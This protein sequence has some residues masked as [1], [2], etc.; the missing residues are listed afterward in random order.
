VLIKGNNKTVR[1][2]IDCFYNRG[3]FLSL[4]AMNTAYLLLGSNE[5]DR[6][7]HLSHALKLIDQKAGTL[8][9]QSA[10]YVT[11]A[12]GNAEQPDFLNQVV[13]ITT[14]LSPQ[15]LLNALLAIE[16][17]IGRIRTGAKW[18]Q[19]IIDLDILFYNDLVMATEELTIP[20][21]FLQDRKFVLVPLLEIAATYVHPVFQKSVAALTDACIDQLEVKKLMIIPH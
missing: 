6:V 9:K 19:R 20:H 5:G 4:T 14:D 8:A 2:F 12:W 21:P 1:K 15:Q 16:Q 11:V 10:I 17:E 3:C 13:C 7:Q 18:M